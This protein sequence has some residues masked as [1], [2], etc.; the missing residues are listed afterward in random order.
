MKD[1]PLVSVIIP[2]YNRA[3]LLPR[4]IDSVL[5]QTYG[6]VEIVVV[7]DG[8]TDN[9][10]S[11]LDGYRDKIRRIRT[12]NRGASHARNVG[13][14]A[15]VGRYI[16]F[17]DSDDSY[18]PYKLSLQVDWM[19]RHPEI[20]MVSSE[21]SGVQDDENI[22]EYHLKQYHTIYEER[23]WEFEDI[24][25][26]HEE[27]FIDGLGRTVA[28]Y[29][30]NIFD[31]ALMGTLVMSN[32]ILFR[33]EALDVA[34][35]QNETY[36]FAEDYEFVLRLCKHFRVG[37]INVPTYRMYYH[38]GQISRFLT[39]RFLTKKTFRENKEDLLLLEGFNVMLTAVVDSAFND[40]KY[41][42]KHKEKVDYRMAEL[43]EEIGYLW[44]KC[45]DYGKGRGFLRKSYEIRGKRLPLLRSCIV[46]FFPEK[47]KRL[48]RKMRGTF[49]SKISFQS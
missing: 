14:R 33:K 34:G 4:A 15:S 37:F 12:G 42:E 5:A 1:S 27:I 40:Y 24:Y 25:Q 17:L 30:G 29:S 49:M 22:L 6:N 8:S 38:D 13:M 7:D 28:C 44:C 43:N 35:Y 23:G 48:I 21:V 39:K 18:Y 16:A 9:T 20:G 26:E 36:R 32:T 19:E 11:V 41:Y 3:P 45:G 31:Y 2:T 47:Y 10:Q 46:P